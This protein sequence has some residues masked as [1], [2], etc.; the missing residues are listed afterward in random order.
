MP[1]TK[2]TTQNRTPEKDKTKRCVEPDE[3]AKIVGEICDHNDNIAS[4]LIRIMAEVGRL[5]YEPLIVDAFANS[6]THAAFMHTLASC[7]ARRAYVDQ[8][9]PE[10]REVSI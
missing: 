9:C 3:I 2:N 8:L 10:A 4:S 6:V 1:G 7:E 5:A